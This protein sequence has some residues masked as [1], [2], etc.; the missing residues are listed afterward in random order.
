MLAIGI[1]QPSDTTEHDQNWSHMM[2]NRTPIPGIKYIFQDYNSYKPDIDMSD[3]AISVRAHMT[4]DQRAIVRLVVTAVDPD[5]NCP[6]VE[7]LLTH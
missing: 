3:D 6:D 7:S 1:S 2:Y 4:S 5:L